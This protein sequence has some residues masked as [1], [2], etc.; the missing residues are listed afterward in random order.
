MK[1]R[2][3]DFAI[4]PLIL[5]RWS[6]RAMSGQPITNEELMTLF[7]A[8][9]WAPSSYNSQP[10]R[11]IYALRDT[12][13]WKTFFSLLIPFNQSWT[14]RAAALVVI[15]SRKTFERGGK[16]SP[17]HSFDTGAAWENLALQAQRMQLVAHGMS[18]FDWERAR[19]ELL[20][21]DDYAVEAMCAIGRKGKIEDLPQDLRSREEPSE[22]KPLNELI[23]EGNFRES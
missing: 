15:V 9:R 20:I 13:A 16:P 22:R 2:K 14:Q 10:W 21:P 1:K 18:G 17:T 12:P 19:K 11:F 8:A 4:D 23:F 7:E 3:T 5:Q 6:P